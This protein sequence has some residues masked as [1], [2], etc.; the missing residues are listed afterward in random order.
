MTANRMLK[1]ALNL[2]GAIV[3]NFSF[4]ENV[5]RKR[6]ATKSRCALRIKWSNS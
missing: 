6:R 3:E 4:G 5:D 2:K 1:N